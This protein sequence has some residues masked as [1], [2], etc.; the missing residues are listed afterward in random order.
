MSANP[1]PLSPP[2]IQVLQIVGNAIVGGMEIY[3]Q[4]LVERLPPERFGVCVLCPDEGPFADQLRAVGAEVVITPMPDNPPW[5]AIQLACTLIKARNVDV[6]Q[7]HMSN[8]HMLAGL[9][10]RI[11]D[12]PVVGTVHGRQLSTL[13]VE[14]HRIAGT[15]ISVVCQQTYFQ[16]LGLGINPS[17][18]HLI[19]N[20]VDIEIFKPV[21]QRNGPLRQGFGIDEAVPLVGFIG[22]LSEEKG[23]DVFLRVAAAVHHVLPQVHFVLV[24][25]GPML[26]RLQRFVAQQRL[27][28][29]VH[30]AG[31]R[32]DMPE[33]YAELD[34]V[35]ST[36]HTEGMPLALM[37]AM[38][39]GLAVV[40]T[41]VG[42]VPELVQQG[43]TGWI[44]SAG[45]VDAM[46]DHMVDLLQA[47]EQLKAMGAKA[48]IRAEER[49]SLMRG[50]QNTMDLLSM[51]A[52]PRNH[53][54][55]LT[56]SDAKAALNPAPLRQG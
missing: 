45:D 11:T 43:I 6:I 40:A 32:I 25:R 33:V 24:G 19:P 42:G 48:R 18:L 21:R 44:A 47:P 10:G 39:C 41:R 56:L 12:R 1:T 52:Q 38:A 15:H 55:H 51:L 9:A 13:D 28:G 53:Q 36:S 35:A 4:R 7:A 23:P 29:V 2:R 14:M 49:F 50:V 54:R 22:R 37:E 27:G 8:A 3:V 26:A 17:R 46:A 5:F 16:A 34:M 20:G 31:V 30:F